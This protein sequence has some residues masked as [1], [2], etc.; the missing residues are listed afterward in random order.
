MSAAAALSA[1]LR[2]PPPAARTRCVSNGAKISAAQAA[3]FY[4]LRKGLLTRYL[5]RT[6]SAVGAVGLLATR[7]GFVHNDHIAMRAFVESAG[8][9]GLQFLVTL[10]GAFGY[11][12]REAVVIPG[13]PVN[14]TWLEPPESTDWPKVFVSELRVTELPSAAG[15][16]VHS[17][18]DGVYVSTY[19]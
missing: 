15:S 8:Q 4:E 12:Q 5:A 3:I 19:I 14:A 6:P 7:G 9:S 10:F 13:L 1:L 18:I 16:V 17:L 11:A 2:G